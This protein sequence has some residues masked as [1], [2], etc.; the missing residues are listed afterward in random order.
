MTTAT[1]TLI[2][3]T[4]GSLDEAKAIGASL[5]EQRLAA[6]VNILPGMISQYYWQGT[7]R[8]DDEVVLIAK[9][10]IDLV[11]ALTTH[12]LAMHSY[13]C[14]CL[15]TLPI[16]DGNPAFLQWIETETKDAVQ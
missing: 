5:V 6:C 12:V 7:V 14:P 16:Q 9:T 3:M 13:D 4:A 2:Y 11:E 1:A 8:S 10:T 15:V